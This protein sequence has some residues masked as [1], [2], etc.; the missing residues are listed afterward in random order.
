[1]AG[2]DA[3][4]AP[5]LDG[6]GLPTYPLT[7]GQLAT[8]LARLG[9][10]AGLAPDRQV[11]CRRICAAM[12]GHPQLVAG[13]GRACTAV[14]TLAP[15]VVVK[16]GAEGVYGAALPRLKL[17]LALKVEDGGSRAAPVALLALLEALRAL[18]PAQRSELDQVARPVLRNHAGR[19]V[20]RIEPATGWPAI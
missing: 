18:T 1:M 9:D 13:S 7:L 4:P 17:G 2:L 14:M 8:A 15:E 12:S 5:G 16:T 3:L 19:V 6:C 20:G 11:A 10:P